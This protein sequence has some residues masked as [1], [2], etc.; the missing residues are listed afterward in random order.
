MIDFLSQEWIAGN[1]DKLFLIGLILSIVS[2]LCKKILRKRKETKSI[3]KSL[4][5]TG[6]IQHHAKEII[7]N[8]GN[9]VFLNKIKE[10]ETIVREYD[11]LFKMRFDDIAVTSIAV[12]IVNEIHE[13]T[14]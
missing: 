1:I 9:E 3:K 4:S 5:E 7:S 12:E 11:D 8:Y 2:F 13:K 6:F 14:G 10:I